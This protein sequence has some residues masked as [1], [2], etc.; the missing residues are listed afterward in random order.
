MRTKIDSSK[1]EQLQRD[2]DKREPASGV[3]DMFAPS[4]KPKPPKKARTSHR[5]A[6]ERAMDSARELVNHGTLSDDRRLLVGLYAISHETVYGAV[7]QELERD[8]M[9]ARSSAAKLIR[10][11]FEGNIAAAIHFVRWC[12]SREQARERKRKATKT[13]SDFRISWRFQF[14][15][16]SLLTDYRVEGSR[17]AS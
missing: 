10:D 9:A 4:T 16:R 1:L 11:E 14:V 8:F 5:A 13:Q 12:W 17:R 6:F 7:P 2:A 15:S 3:F